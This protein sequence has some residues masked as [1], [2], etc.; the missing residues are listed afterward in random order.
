MNDYISQG[1]EALEVG[2]SE[3]AISLLTQALDL[4]PNSDDAYA[5]RGNAYY[6]L[7]EYALALA[8]LTQALRLN[9]DHRDA[10]HFR[11]QTN[12]KLN[13]LEAALAD[14]TTDLELNPTNADS[15]FN[16]A[17]VYEEFGDL[18]AAIADYSAAIEL[19]PC[20]VYYYLRGSVKQRMTDFTG[21]MADFSAGLE[22]DPS[23]AVCYSGRAFLHTKLDDLDSALADYS[24]AIA[25]EPKSIY[26]HLRGCV[27]NSMDDLAGAMADYDTAIELDST[28]GDAYYFRGRAHHRLED[29]EASIA[30]LTVAIEIA[31]NDTASYM[32]RAW[33]YEKAESWAE[34]I[35]DYTRCLQLEPDNA[36]YW[37]WRGLIYQTVGQEAA[38]LADFRHACQLNPDLMDELEPI[39]RELQA[40]LEAHSSMDDPF[41]TPATL[42]SLL[43]ELEALIGLPNV[44]QEVTKLINFVRVQQMRRDRGMATPPLSLHMVFTG[45]PGTGKTTVARLISRIFN[46]LGL[47]SSGHLVEVDR[48]GLV[49]GFVGQTALKTAEVIRQARG[50][51]LFI[52]EAYTLNSKGGNDYGQ[53]A[54]DTLLKGME[55]YRN[56]LIVV[57]AGYAKPMVEFL[58]S[59]PGLQSRFNRY[60]LFEDYTD[61]ELYQILQLFCTES[62]YQLASTAEDTLL[63]FIAEQRHCNPT[64]FGNA[65]GVRNLF[66]QAVA[67]QASR[68]IDAGAVSD[69]DL[70]MLTIADFGATSRLQAVG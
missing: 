48:S 43:A 37:H 1:L 19:S 69:A 26:Y 12:E 49:A 46:V 22:L 60:V 23:S 36:H 10:Y 61:T 44:K 4:N 39:L 67:T 41:A 2:D 56:D 50:G 24:A 18:D 5:Y 53:E 31:C 25:L 58:S 21:A 51:V 38:A 55:D 9:P 16:R 66:E 7:A 29:F 32:M 47:L 35:A 34:A 14:Y 3:A 68:I 63:S 8:D 27:K 52:D 59:N 54:I 45:N 70:A 15:Y 33:S 40:N 20:S 65:R 57:V 64:A 30:D 42:E 13:C 11:G 28:N 62:G 17:I 6:N